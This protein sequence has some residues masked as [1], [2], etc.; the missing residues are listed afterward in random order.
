MICKEKSFGTKYGWQCLGGGGVN[1]EMNIADLISSPFLF[2]I[3][4]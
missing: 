4:R 2:F 1:H 3:S